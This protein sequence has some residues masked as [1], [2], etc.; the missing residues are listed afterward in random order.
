MRDVANKSGGSGH[1]FATVL[2]RG[3]DFDLFSTIAARF[4]PYAGSLLEFR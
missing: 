4:S 3:H 2:R 1:E